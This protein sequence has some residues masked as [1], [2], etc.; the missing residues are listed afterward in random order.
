MGK[1][2]PNPTGALTVRW[3]RRSPNRIMLTR[4]CRRQRSPER[5]DK[6]LK[7]RENHRN[8]GKWEDWDG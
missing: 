5:L 1:G 7:T 2:V 4:V 6:C 8:G 3:V